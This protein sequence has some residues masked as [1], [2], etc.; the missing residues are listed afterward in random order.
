MPEEQAL[1]QGHGAV[2]EGVL[3]QGI[4]MGCDIGAGVAARE[5]AGAMSE[6]VDGW[7]AFLLLHT[8]PISSSS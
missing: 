6:W 7:I 8:R 5:S 1:I 3:H 4:Q 2:V